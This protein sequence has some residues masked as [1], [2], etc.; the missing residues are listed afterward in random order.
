MYATAIIV[1]CFWAGAASLLA[2]FFYRESDQQQRLLRTA[3]S[4]RDQA[5]QSYKELESEVAPRVQ[6]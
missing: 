6:Q 5:K 2:W 4:E 1:L 3:W